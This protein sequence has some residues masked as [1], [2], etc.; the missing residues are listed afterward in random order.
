M[1]I[2]SQ[3]LG[4]INEILK[5]DQL[6]IYRGIG[7]QVNFWNKTHLEYCPLA[8]NSMNIDKDIGK[9]AKD[10]IRESRR[11]RLIL[12]CICS[13]ING[14]VDMP[15][16]VHFHYITSDKLCCCWC[17]NFVRSMNAV[18]ASYNLHTTKYNEHGNLNAFLLC[19]YSTMHTSYLLAFV[20]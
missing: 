8:F 19:G 3:A 15:V 1:F 12:L 9:L 16:R 10:V 17:I 18:Y 14:S 11:S 7:E 4:T 6:W 2:D 13:S 20:Q 5:I